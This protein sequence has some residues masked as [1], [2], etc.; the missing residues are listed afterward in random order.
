MPE[1]IATPRP[2]TDAEGEFFREHG[3]VKL[4]QLISTDAAAG[5]LR[6][7][8]AKMGARAESTAHPKLNDGKNPGGRFH[9]YSPLSVEVATGAVLDD[10][11]HGFS[12]SPE[13]G[14]AGA[15]LWGE[16][17]RFW[18]DQA[19]V[20]TPASFADGSS[21]TAW[22]VD[23]SGVARS[24]FADP[25]AQFLIWLAL[26][27]VPRERGAMRFVSPQD[28]TDEVWETV[29]SKP[30][31]ET[32]EIFEQQGILSPPLDLK[33]GDATVHNGATLHSAPL[34]TTDEIRWIYNA[35]MFP[36]RSTWTGEVFWP[37]EGTEMQVGETFPDFRFPVLA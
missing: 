21:E 1:P 17:V 15:K 28:I 22:H 34:N 37:N 5:L 31:L 32:Y 35:I 7:I 30:L 11:F 29:R 25:N 20:K 4:D 6:L 13:M 8:Q 27:D 33:A 18:A 9:T 14:Q 10:A 19:L 2:I 23:I 16:S 3:W 26:N 24:P 12:H 36:A